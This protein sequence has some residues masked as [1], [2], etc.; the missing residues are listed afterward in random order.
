MATCAAAMLFGFHSHS[1]QAADAAAGAS[2]DKRIA[3][4]EKLF[5][6]HCSECHNATDWAG[7]LALD[8]LDVAHIGEEA[9]TGEK[10][11]AKLRAGVM[12]PYGKHRPLRSELLAAVNVIEAKI[13]EAAA[14]APA[15]IPPPGVHRLNRREYANAI[16]DL[17]AL[18]IDP[19]SMLPVD[20]SSYGFD[21][22]AGTL[23]SSPALVGAY[24]SAASK[25]S[26]LA[27]GHETEPKLATY[28]AAPDY[29]QDRHIEGL[30][31]GTR[32]GLMVRH[33]F[34]ADGEYV[35]NWTPVRT[36]AGGIFGNTAGE[37][38]ELSVD[39]QTVKVYDIDAEIERNSPKDEHPVR[40]AVRAGMRTVGLTFV[41]LAE[42]P[43]DDLNAHFER[44]T[45][46]QN[47]DG[48]N[49][50][51]HVN[52]MT[53]LGP[54]SGKRPASTA[55]RDKA[56]TCR[57][58]QPAEETACASKIFTDLAL[59]AFRRPIGDD[60][61]KAILALY[62]KTREQGGDFEEGVQIGLQLI[63]SDPHFIY[64]TEPA[65]AGVAPG[66]SWAVSDL[67]LASRLSFFLWSTIPDQELLNLASAGKLREPR[68]L[69]QQ[70]RRM[71][72]DPRSQELVSNFVGQWLQ[73]RNLN[74]AA[75]V[76]DIFPNF[77]DNLRQ[78]FRTEVE[79]LFASLLHEDRSVRELLDARYSFLNERL[80]RHYGIP[81]VYGSQFR[82]VELGPEFDMRR[83]LL[84]KGAILTVTSNA[85]RTSTI[86]RGQWV[87]VNILG[88]RP[89]DPPPNVPGLAAQEENPAGGKKLQTLR[90]RMT[91]HA[92]NPACA[93]CHQMMD[94][95][96]F[97]MESFDGIGR[98][99]TKDAGQSLDLS[100]WLVDG[101]RFNGVS[102]LREALMTYSPEFI[103]TMTIRLMTY[104][105]G[106]GVEYYDMPVVR[107]ILK[108][109]D[110]RDDRFSALVLGIVKSDSF[111]KNQAVEKRVAA[112]QGAQ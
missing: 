37:K 69:E 59:R 33:Y 64:R 90:Q 46:T 47:L 53:I 51:P 41:S 92:T 65:P 110:A 38:L 1:A 72:A 88:V 23:G 26:R 80:A 24:V 39:G 25:I 43:R 97:A 76:A 111:Q 78:D 42:S 101:T 84:G 13:D 82:R 99:R 54:Y 73:L 36:N 67:E 9:E 48:F 4:V 58:A 34:P 22:I 19:G 81:N 40:I 3:I 7:G 66:Q 60:D 49:F 56:L 103:K 27:L 18:E 70:V 79:M 86:R 62:R 28:H 77:D 52:S 102:Q 109:A 29:S 8:T 44:T 108:D 17:L 91:E 83:G 106:R 95:I 61:L 21:N 16:R 68:V 74:A 2:A 55:S 93:A 112:V 89:P 31:F 6:T 14:Q 100:G 15:S 63:L 75:P 57:P 12:P 104:A 11:I 50:A 107:S 85:D 94:P 87:D 32:G 45:L 71:L 10:I 98:V 35:F 30:P 5:D 105:L 96:G 20:D